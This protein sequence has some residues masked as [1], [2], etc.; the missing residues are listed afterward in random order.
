MILRWALHFASGNSLFTG[1]V[2]LTVVCALVSFS[3]FRK[4][5]RAWRLVLLVAVICVALS[6]T[7]WPWFVYA[8][9]LTLLGLWLWSLRRP[10][11]EGVPVNRRTQLLGLTLILFS[12]VACIIEGLTLLPHSE[13]ADH[14]VMYVIGDSITAGLNEDDILWPTILTDA[15]HV[16]VVN[17]AQP[18][19]MADSAMK[20][21]QDI[22]SESEGIILIEI[23]GNDQLSGRSAEVYESDLRKLLAAVA[24]SNRTIVL[25][26]LPLAPFKNAYGRVQRQLAVEY[27]AVLISKR[28]F[29][30]VLGQADGTLDGIH[31]SAAG[32]E[33]MADVVWR[34]VR[35]LYSSTSPTSDGL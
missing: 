3:R 10:T 15:H 14:H 33:R 9:W 20:Q 18:G 23:G 25:M 1:V 32:Q 35:P 31:L 2:I 28:E 34:A 6:A 19:A 26:E 27:N 16:D 11:T 24:A 8:M 5:E 17:L 4:Y 29:A 22:P 7:P 30:S 13:T 21:A 12:V